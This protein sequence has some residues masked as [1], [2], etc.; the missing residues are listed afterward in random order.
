VVGGTGGWGQTL[1]PEKENIKLVK[2][3]NIKPLVKKTKL[4]RKRR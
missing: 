1:K 3:E 4:Q 2:K